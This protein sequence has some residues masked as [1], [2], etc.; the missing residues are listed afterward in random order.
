M[1]SKTPSAPTSD[2]T[3][4]CAP[5]WRK[6]ASASS[7][8]PNCA[9]IQA[10]LYVCGDP[11]AGTNP[12][13][14][15]DPARSGCSCASRPTSQSCGSGSTEISRPGP[16]SPATPCSPPVVHWSVGHCPTLLAAG[17]FPQSAERGSQPN[18]IPEVLQQFDGR[19]RRLLK[20]WSYGG[21]RRRVECSMHVHTQPSRARRRTGRRG[22]RTAKSTLR[23]QPCTIRSTGSG[24]GRTQSVHWRYHSSWRYYADWRRYSSI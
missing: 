8:C 12:S 14:T 11:C 24:C 22:G 17:D 2:P 21:R 20:V 13:A 7:S 4:I 16:T 23:P 15:T 9:R 6:S 10:P 19:L 5:G 3:S 18:E 1:R